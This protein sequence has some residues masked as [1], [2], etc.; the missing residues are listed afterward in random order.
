[1]GCGCELNK[2]KLITVPIESFQLA[3]PDIYQ[4]A[5]SGTMGSFREFAA[6]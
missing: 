4:F 5:A 2:R 3:K 6:L 1:M